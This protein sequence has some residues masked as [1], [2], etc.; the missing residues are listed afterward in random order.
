MNEV[1][2]PAIEPVTDDDLRAAQNIGERSGQIRLVVILEQDRRRVAERQAARPLE[3]IDRDESY[4]RSYIPVAPGWEVQTKGKGSTFRLCEPSGDRLA[5]PDSPYLHTTIERMALA[6]HA[7]RVAMEEEVERLRAALARR[8]DEIADCEPFLK[9]GERLDECIER[10]RADAAAVLDLLVQ[11]K[12]KSE[13]LEAE[14]AAHRKHDVLRCDALM[15]AEA[16]VARL[17]AACAAKDEALR[18]LTDMDELR[19]TDELYIARAAL[20]T[21]ASKG[22]IDATGAVEA[23]V[24]GGSISTV[25]ATVPD[26]WAGSRVLIVRVGK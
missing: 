25:V 15:K 8:I 12:K 9:E 13:A 23:L 2:Q 4:G 21:D 10:W 5:V 19:E 3:K 20:S 7:H 16:E 11:E 6:I 26:E 17:T 14:V 1:N 24:G 18:L 22:R